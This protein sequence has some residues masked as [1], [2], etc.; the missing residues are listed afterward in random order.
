MLLSV[1]RDSGGSI[2]YWMTIE[3]HDGHRY[4]FTH[5]QPLMELAANVN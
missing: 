3:E 4:E 2:A 5:G 1:P